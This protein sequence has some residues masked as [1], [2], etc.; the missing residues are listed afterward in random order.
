MTKL[1]VKRILLTLLVCVSLV[2]AKAYDFCVNG[3]YYNIIDETASTLEVTYETGKADNYEGDVVI[4]ST[5]E[6]DGKHYTVTGIGQRAFWRCSK[7]TSLKLPETLTHIGE[8][9]MFFCPLIEEIEVPEGVTV[10]EASAFSSC[11]ALKTITLPGKLMYISDWLFDGC[12]SLESVSLPQTVKSIGQGAFNFC[13]SLKEIEISNE[14]T[15]I[16]DRAFSGCV[17]LQKVVFPSELTTIGSSAFARCTSLKEIRL[18][19]K[20]KEIAVFAFSNCSSLETVYCMASIPPV[21]EMS[22]NDNVFYDVNLKNVT[23]FVPK[24]SV[25]E[26]SEANQWKEFGCIVEAAETLPIIV[27]IENVEKQKVDDAMFKLTCTVHCVNANHLYVDVEEEDNPAVRSYYFDN[28]ADVKVETGNITKMYDSRVVFRAVNDLGTTQKVLEFKAG[29]DMVADG[30]YYAGTDGKLY[31]IDNDGNTQSL[32]GA[33]FP[34]TFQ[35]MRVGERIYGASAGTKFTYSST[36][37]ADGDGKLFYVS[38][39]FGEPSINIVLDNTGANHNRDPYGLATY[40]DDIFVYDR[41]E[42]IRKISYNDTT[43][44]QDYP[45]WLENNWID[46]YGNGWSYGCIKSDMQITEGFDMSGNPEP[47]FWLSMIY[48]GQGIFR[49]KEAA[50][51]EAGSRHS[52]YNKSYLS[53]LYA[54]AFYIDETNGYLYMYKEDR[55]NSGVFRIKL[56]EIENVSL[57]VLAKPELIDGAP[58]RLEGSTTEHVGIPQLSVDANGEY[59]YW[60][61]RAPANEDDYDTDLWSMKYDENNPLHRTGIKRIKLG[62]ETPKVEMVAEG[63]DGYGVIAIN[64]TKSGLGTVNNIN[65]NNSSEG[66]VE[67]YNLQGMRVDNPKT[68]SIVIKKQG[69]VVSKILVR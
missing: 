66:T 4:P 24:G 13:N 34:H 22:G 31:V 26:Y 15:I 9:A 7:L 60:C 10:I 63:A 55:K 45:S 27:K 68:G 50:I 57:A 25:S 8:A 35:L 65:A 18:G 48:N 2:T 40:N 52:A 49:F 56:S 44:P 61:Y 59:L 58:V 29:E 1:N 20:V 28:P 38:N 6:K 67:Y 62:E 30:L 64:Y 41:N 42:I 51:S 19:Q 32:D 16:P 23:L 47:V 3:I 54:T 17:S 12:S 46:F 14:V 33:E 69:S 53:G 5:V 36:P 43:I 39:K 37:V 21:C 11:S